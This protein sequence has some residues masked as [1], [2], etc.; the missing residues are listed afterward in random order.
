MDVVKLR[1]YE[2][3][4]PFE[5]KDFLAKAASKTAGASSV[6][7]LNA[8]RGNPNWIATE[9]REA[10]FLLGQ[11]AIT[12]SKRVLDL[13][14]GVGGMPQARGTVAGVD[15]VHRCYEHRGADAARRAESAALVREELRV[16]AR[17]LEHVPA[18]VEHCE[19]TRGRQVLE[20]NAAVE[21]GRVDADARRTADLHGLRVGGAGVL[22]HLS[23]RHAERIFVEARPRD[24]ASHRE[25]LRARGLQRAERAVP[26]AAVHGDQC[27]RAQRL[28]VVDDRGLL[29]VAVRDRIRRAVTRHAALA[30]ER[31]DQRG[32]L[33]ADVRARADVDPDVEVETGLPADAV[34]EQFRFA[35]PFERRLERVEQV[36]VLA[37]QVQEAVAGADRVGGHR[38]AVEHEVGVAREQHTVLERAGLALVG[39]ADHVAR[40]TRRVPACLPLDAGRE[41]R[42]AAA[43]QVRALDLLERRDRALRRAD[44]CF[45]PRALVG[46]T[47]GPATGAALQRRADRIAGLQRMA[48]QDVRPAHVVLHDEE[49]RGP[50]RE[51]RAGEDQLADLFDALAGQRRNR[52]PVDEERGSLVAHAGARRPADADE[53]VLGHLAGLDPEPVAHRLHQA[54][55]ASHPIGDVVGEQHPVGALRVD[56]QERVEARHT[57]HPRVR[58]AQ[59][60]R[61]QR[62]RGTRQAAEL[63]L[64]LAQHLH[65]ARRVVSPMRQDPPHARLEVGELFRD[66]VH[67]L[68]DCTRGDVSHHRGK[69]QTCCAS[70]HAPGALGGPGGRGA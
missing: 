7:Y 68:P 56:D 11:F 24:V 1:Q 70:R 5:I 15:L 47:L 67:A 9:P 59:Q 31:L 33:A 46:R 40:E 37:A 19:R 21:L 50:L 30:L 51:R 10:F 26:V 13:P 38:H 61:D 27:R 14:P 6:A 22:E 66:C 28:D 8:G 12:E 25:D 3:L 69:P 53:P 43:A 41:A 65:E 17:D 48:K 29:P 58:D 62:E 18:C 39:I 49:L 23:H 54:L 60:P 20:R 63:L 4:S 2:G 64:D 57:R 42:A 36:A 34:A 32:F 44:V 55:A 52:A 16:V 45:A 35:A